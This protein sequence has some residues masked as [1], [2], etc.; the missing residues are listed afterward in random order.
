MELE[1]SIGILSRIQTIQV[2]RCLK[3][4][5]GSEEQRR[6][7][8]LLDV[9]FLRESIAKPKEAGLLACPTGAPSR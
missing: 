1:G 9:A 7:K 3:D 8:M 5:K 2:T 6:W 4:R